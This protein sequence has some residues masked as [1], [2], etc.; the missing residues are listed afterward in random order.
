MYFPGLFSGWLGRISIKN[1]LYIKALCYTSGSM[2][3][4]PTINLTGSIAR[5]PAKFMYVIIHQ[6]KITGCYTV[7]RQIVCRLFVGIVG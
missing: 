7:R 1:R 4:W 5:L 3:H 6:E 2:F